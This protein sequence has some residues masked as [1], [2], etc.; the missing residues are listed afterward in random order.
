MGIIS[1]I[2]GS[3]E[4]HMDKRKTENLDYFEK[5]HG[6]IY[7][8]Y[9]RFGKM[10]HEK[11]GPIGAK[12]RWLIKI[13]LSASC[14]YDL[15]LRTHIEKALASGCSREEIEHAI[16]LTAPTAGFPTMMTALL[17]LRQEMGEA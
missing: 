8:A 7:E 4:E 1:P 5:R 6:D 15:A 12:E 2:I 10:V 16:L 3:K 11:G 14:Q 13:A 17:V 9:Q